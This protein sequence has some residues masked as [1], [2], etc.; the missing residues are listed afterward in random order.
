MGYPD[1]L[2]KLIDAFGKLP[3]IGPKSAERL[4]YHILQTDIKEVN[5]FI[6]ALSSVKTKVRLCTEC[7]SPTMNDT[8]DICSEESRD[9]VTLCIVKNMGALNAIERTKKYN[10]LYH[11]LDRIVSPHEGVIPEKERLNK[12]IDR[13]KLGVKEI[14]IATD[15]DTE[16]EITAN[17]I[18]RAIK[19]NGLKI[20]RLGYGMPVGGTLEYADEIT[21]TRALE[22][23]KEI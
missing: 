20:T 8:C 15:T 10:G 1:T 2:Q 16:G 11:I 7:F 17:Y 5:K 14:I 9:R 22:G 19:K 23:R 3:S 13:I 6:D 12:L 4:A 21:L 18:A